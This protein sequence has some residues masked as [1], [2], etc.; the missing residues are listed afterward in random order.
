MTRSGEPNGSR[1]SLDTVIP[2]AR[3]R[4]EGVQ[5]RPAS[6]RRAAAQGRPEASRGRPAPRLRPR[7]TARPRAFP[8]G[9][10]TRATLSVMI[11]NA[12]ALSARLADLLRA[13][14]VAMADFLLALADFDRRR[15]WVDLGYASL[16]AYLH[17]ELGLSRSAAHYRKTAVELI[18]RFPQVEAAFRSGRLCLTTSFELARVLTPEN[19]DEVLPRFFGLSRRE[20]MEVA[21]SIVPA[22][23]VP[24]RTVVTPVRES[25]LTPPAAALDLGRREAA[26]PVAPARE[27]LPVGTSSPAP[28]RRVEPPARVEVRPLDAERSRIHLTVDRGFHARLEEARDAL[29]HAHPNASDGEILD[30]ALEA[31]LERAAKRKGLGTR[32]PKTPRPAKREHVP[33]HVLAAALERAG[34][35]CEWRLASGGSC[36]SRRRLQADHIQPLAL[37]G[38]SDLAN[39][40]IACAFHNLLAAREVFGDAWMDQFARNPRVA[41]GRRAGMETATGS[42]PALDF[43]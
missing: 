5:G 30:L 42:A 21:A 14:Q 34:H 4:G 18:Q 9:S 38:T 39:I 1:P 33:A 20:A 37:G 12:R 17:R 27:C 6:T 41:A 29:S 40:R 10:K 32:R 24:E 11:T 2:E 28:S 35:C 15:L 26:A 8:E 22:E 3:F 23:T 13:E 7:F 31:L 19:L 36:G 25:A 43:G 16:F